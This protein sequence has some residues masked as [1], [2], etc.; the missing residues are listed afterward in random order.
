M[1][2]SLLRPDPKQRPRLLEIRDNL[3]QRIEEAEQQ[4]WLGEAEGLKVSLTAAEEKITQLEAR[5]AKSAG[6]IDLGIPTLN[7]TQRQNR[8][9]I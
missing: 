8:H 2:C 6:P 3:R 1:R 4:G 5:A 9:N 7:D